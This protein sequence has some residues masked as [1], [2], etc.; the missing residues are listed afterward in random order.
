MQ[1]IQIKKSRQ[2][3]KKLQKLVFHQ[4]PASV[5]AAPA[6]S[7]VSR[8]DEIEE[9]KNNLCGWDTIKGRGWGWTGDGKQGKAPTNTNITYITDPELRK[10]WYGDYEHLWINFSKPP[11]KN[12]NKTNSE[13]FYI[14]KEQQARNVLH[15]HCISFKHDTETID[16][17]NPYDPYASSSECSSEC[18]YNHK[19]ENK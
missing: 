12:N 19:N 6:P 16:A 5:I 14:A 3:P 13:H 4:A 8:S 7:T 10:K 15:S 1:Q 17:G 11:W 18:S 9:K 2:P